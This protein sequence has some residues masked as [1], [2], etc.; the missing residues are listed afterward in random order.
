MRVE[1]IPVQPHIPSQCVDRIGDRNVLASMVPRSVIPMAL[2]VLASCQEPANGPVVDATSD[3]GSSSSTS[4]SDST[5]TTSSSE[6]STGAS[7]TD[8]SAGTYD[9]T[10]TTDGQSSTTEVST[11]SGG[12]C[13]LGEPACP[14][15]ERGTCDRGFECLELIDICIEPVD[16]S[17]GTPGC[18]CAEDDTC[19][20]GL[21]CRRGY[22]VSDMPCSPEYTGME[23]CQCLP[24]GSCDP[25][26]TCSSGICVNASGTTTGG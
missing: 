23:G 19:E 25:E 21:V 24:D 7:V 14:C 10:S 26:L 13:Q 3:E 11:T 15:T 20:Q 9:T 17:P 5:S 22:C 16:C 8:V 18:T 2:A 4:G 6:S 12:A 1:W